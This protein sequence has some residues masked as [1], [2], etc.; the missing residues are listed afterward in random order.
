MSE[1]NMQ[2]MITFQKNWGKRKIKK[3]QYCNYKSNRWTKRG[4]YSVH[5]KKNY[6]N[7]LFKININKTCGG[8][9]GSG[10]ACRKGRAPD[11]LA[12]T[13]WRQSAWGTRDAVARLRLPQLQCGGGSRHGASWAMKLELGHPCWS[14]LV[15]RRLRSRLELCSTLV[16]NATVRGTVSWA[17][18]N[19]RSACRNKDMR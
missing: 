10:W 9:V 11:G 14:S 12:G 13:L 7:K 16:V 8:I 4:T 6:Q 18:L 2:V 1:K 3:M 19:V 15:N 17:G 5:D